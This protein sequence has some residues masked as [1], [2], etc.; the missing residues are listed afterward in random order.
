MLV[1]AVAA[2]VFLG[3]LAFATFQTWGP[4][5]LLLLL[6]LVRSWWFWIGLVVI[7]GIVLVDY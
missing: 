5:V 2:G 7:C 6:G 1:I 4:V 3:L